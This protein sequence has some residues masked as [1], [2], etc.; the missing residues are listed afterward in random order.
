MDTFFLSFKQTQH[1]P[2]N[3]ELL[4]YP[5]MASNIFAKEL[6]TGKCMWVKSD[7]LHIVNCILLC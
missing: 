3:K 5:A 1:L 7:L 6:C 4:L 2:V